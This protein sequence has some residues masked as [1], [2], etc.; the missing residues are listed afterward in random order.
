MFRGDD[1]E[2]NLHALE[3]T[4][5]PLRFDTTLGVS[6]STDDRLTIIGAL[7]SAFLGGGW[8]W[9]VLA[10]LKQRN[11]A[12]AQKPKDSGPTRRAKRPRTG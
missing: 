6:A 9:Q 3:A 8:L 12:D 1:L 5:P 2:V 11:S 4:F 7:A 10:W